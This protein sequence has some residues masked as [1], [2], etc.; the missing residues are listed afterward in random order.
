MGPPSLLDDCSVANVQD[1]H[2]RCDDTNTM[3]KN[4]FLYI[5][6]PSLGCSL[7]ELLL[8]PVIAKVLGLIELVVVVSPLD[9]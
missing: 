1:V 5:E 9:C 8:E 6:L 2:A 3:F 7:T 4:Q